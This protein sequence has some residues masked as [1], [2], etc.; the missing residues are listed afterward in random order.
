MNI[1]L[2]ALLIATILVQPAFAG[3]LPETE[4][5]NLTGETMHFPADF[6]GKPTLVIFAF[7]HEQRTETGRV[8]ELLEKAHQ[9]NDGLNWY[10]LPII[11]APSVAH[12][13]IKNG[14]RSGTDKTLHAHIVPQFVDETEWRTSSGIATTEPLLAKV[15]HEGKILKSAPLSTIKTVADIIRF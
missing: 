8:I 1:R 13:F 4:M 11:D 12:F 6:N 10:E 15:D 3:Q 7:A 14:M 9:T 2:L 5:D